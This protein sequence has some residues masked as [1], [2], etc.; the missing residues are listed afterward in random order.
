M[1]NK[2]GYWSDEE[3]VAFAQAIER[4][5]IIAIV[6]GHTH[7]C[8]FYKWGNASHEY[9]VFNAAEMLQITDRTLFTTLRAKFGTE[10]GADLGAV[11]TE[12]R[13]HIPRQPAPDVT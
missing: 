7:S 6:H 11:P 3:G 4:N 2:A 1:N 13:R 9:D 8:N 10:F 5:N 12:H